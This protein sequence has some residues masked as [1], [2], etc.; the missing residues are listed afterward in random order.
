[1]NLLVGNED[2]MKSFMWFVLGAVA[3]RFLTIVSGYLVLQNYA[4]RVNEKVATLVIKIVEECVFIGNV[5]YKILKENGVS[6]GVIERLRTE[7][8][9]HINSWLVG[10]ASYFNGV[11]PPSYLKTVDFD[12]WKEILDKHKKGVNTN[13]S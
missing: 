12:N 4:E 1:M 8:Q 9:N 10:V 7:D 2:L 13:I 3:Y 6:N 5:K 11:Y